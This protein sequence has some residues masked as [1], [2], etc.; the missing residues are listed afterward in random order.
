VNYPFILS[1][2]DAFINTL[3]VYTVSN[4]LFV[5]V[6]SA[7]SSLEQLTIHLVGLNDHSQRSLLEVTKQK[8]IKV[9][10]IS[11]FLDLEFGE[12]VFKSNKELICEL[13]AKCSTDM[14]W[15]EESLKIQTNATV[16]KLK[17]NGRCKALVQ[18]FPSLKKLILDEVKYDEGFLLKLKVPSLTVYTKIELITFY[19]TIKK[20]KNIKSFKIERVCDYYV[21]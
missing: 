6:I 19:S 2:C 20:N 14:L 4:E 15:I 8:K 7:S 10:H 5:K 16:T 11:S 3:D 17:V 9:L 1:I 21:I 18:F 13:I 12:I